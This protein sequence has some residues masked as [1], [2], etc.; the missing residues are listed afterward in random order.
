VAFL[1]PGYFQDM[2]EGFAAQFKNEVEGIVYR[3][4]GI[5]A[6]IVVSPEER[7]KFIDDFEK[8]LRKFFWTTLGS[9]AI[10][11]IL[12]I[13]ISLSL[14]LNFAGL[15]IS[16]ILFFLIYGVWTHRSSSRAFAA[17][18]TAAARRQTSG[19]MVTRSQA[20][21]DWLKKL[22]WSTFVVG[23]A[24][25]TWISYRM[26]VFANPFALDRIFWTIMSLGILLLFAVQAVRKW[27]IEKED[28][29]KDR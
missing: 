2:R 23:P 16:F 18:E 7:Q 12:S 10:M 26:D 19:P 21:R 9:V 29:V 8:Y 24:S 13:V 27:N 14:R 20:R 6:K 28:R 1:E 11:P 3:K 4:N 25:A 5:G 15:C 17:P 22:D